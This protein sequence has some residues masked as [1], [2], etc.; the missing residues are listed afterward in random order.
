VN[1]VAAHRHYVQGL[2]LQS[3]LFFGSANRLYQHVR[4]LLQQRPECRHLVLDFKLV[5]GLDSSAAYSF[6][7]IKHLVLERHI[8]ITLVN[9]RPEAEKMLRVSKFIRDDVSIIGELDHALERCEN[10]V[11]AEHRDLSQE[12]S[13]LRDWFRQMLGSE[14]DAD[15]LIRHCRRIDVEAGDVIVRA[16]DD[17]DS[18]HFL[19]EGRVGVMVATVDDRITRVRSL[20]RYTTIGEM[21]LVAT[22]PRSATIQAEVASVLYVLQGDQ[23]DS[24][25]NDNPALSQKLLIYFVSVMAERLSFA[26][27][28]IGVLRR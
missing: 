12:R 16:G 21:G 23:F 27:R 22:T 14:S 10:E 3:Y 6:A 28:M 19:L 24:I 1:V 18:M 15:E 9:L 20:G 26:S 4:S 13:N 5:T 11:I 17:A 25:K 7:Q 8:K 2:N